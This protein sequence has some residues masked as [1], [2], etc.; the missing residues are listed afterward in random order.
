MT[1]NGTSSN[2]SILSSPQTT[3]KK[4]KYKYKCKYR[5]RCK[6]IC[7]CRYKSADAN[8]NASIIVDAK[9]IANTIVNYARDWLDQSFL[10]PGLVWSKKGFHF[11]YQQTLSCVLGLFWHSDE[12]PNKQSQVSS[13]GSNTSKAETFLKLNTNEHLL[14]LDVKYFPFFP[15]KVLTFLPSRY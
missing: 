13:F 4:Y 7:K 3:T 5:S 8:A 12:R 14:R 2:G 1:Q 15:I 11:G 6:C 10:F 9:T